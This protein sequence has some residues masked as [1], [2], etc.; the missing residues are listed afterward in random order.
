VTKFSVYGDPNNKPRFSSDIIISS[1]NQGAKNLGLYDETGA[2][3]CYSCIGDQHGQNADALIVCY[4]L[5]FPPFI[6]QN[7]Q[8]K[9]IIGVSRDNMM[10]AIHGGFPAHLCNWIPLGVD[11]N[12]WKPVK[13][14][15]LLDK[16]VVLSYT[17][18]LAR[19]GLEILAEAFAKEL[20]YKK[21][22][23]LYIK[24]RNATPEF[25]KWIKDHS[26]KWSYNLIYD[27][28]HISTPEEEIEVFAHADC[29]FYLN[30]STTWGMTV[31]QSMTCGVPT[32]SI[33]YSGPREYLSDDL[34]GLTV[35]Y[36]L[37]PV[38]HD[39]EYLK[40]IGMRDF[41]FPDNRPTYWAKPQIHSVM[42]N[43]GKLYRD[44]NL[45]ERLSYLGREMG[46]SLTWE[47]S[48]ANLS[49]VLNQFGIK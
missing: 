20:G 18:S 47:R 30:R 15:Y 19:S 16:F 4:E 35:D 11:S 31:C 37:E 32:A 1:L 46:K 41:F 38:Q 24:D 26:Q 48:A 23:V 29:H 13:K 3:V 8:G 27:N 21:E 9:P 7:C 34:T 25:E 42:D 5:P 10:F 33:A 44:K 22:C 2:K 12:I 6:I 36:I 43:L 49:Q 40:S 28:R 39:L 45:R 17:E 14:K